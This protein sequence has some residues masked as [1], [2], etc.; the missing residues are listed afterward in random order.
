MLSVTKPVHTPFTVAN[1]EVNDDVALTQH[2]RGAISVIT[3]LCGDIDGNGSINASDLAILTSSS[4]Y[5]KS[6]A[7]AD[8][9]LADL[10][11][12][13]SINASDLAILTSSLN[14]MKGA[15]EEDFGK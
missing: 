13:G 5:M 15:V 14:Y 11:G 8:N 1:I 12:D 10:N 7:E 6:A 4:N 3:L 2:I 9:P